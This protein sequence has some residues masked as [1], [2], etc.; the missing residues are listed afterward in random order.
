MFT[1]YKPARECKEYVLPSFSHEFLLQ[2]LQ[3]RYFHSLLDITQF[4]LQN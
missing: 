3:C 4:I 2:T 1:F